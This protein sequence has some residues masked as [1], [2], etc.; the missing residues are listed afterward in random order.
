MGDLLDPRIYFQKAQIVKQEQ[1]V[2]A[3]DFDGTLTYRD[4]LLPFLSF[5]KGPI[6]TMAG[7]ILAVPYL[8]GALYTPKFRQKAKEKILKETLGG[9]T[10]EQVRKEGEKYAL[11]ALQKKIRPEGLKKLIWHKQQGHRCVLISANLDVYLEPWAF[12]TG[13]HDLIC[14]KVEATQEGKL[15]GNLI[16]LNCW[17]AEKTRRLLQL[18]GPKDQFVL[19]AYGDSQGDRPLLELADYPFYRIFE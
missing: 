11:G 12:N 14:S 17:G 18:V 6:K 9:M 2:A 15:T 1:V 13:F 7:I 19:Y 3:F 4:T 8:C 5:I 16:G 10:I